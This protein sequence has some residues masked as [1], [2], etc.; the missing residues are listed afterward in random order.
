ML[1]GRNIYN[2]RKGFRRIIFLFGEGVV[3]FEEVTLKNTED[4]QLSAK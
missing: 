4:C 2:E 1:H 3:I